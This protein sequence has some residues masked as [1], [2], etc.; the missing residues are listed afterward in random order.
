MTV[1]YLWLNAVLYALSAAW[2]SLRWAA[3]SRS[4]GYLAL[5]AGGRS[6]YLTVYGGLQLGL[7]LCFAWTALRPE[8]HRTGL[9]LALA[10]YLPIVL[11]RLSTVIGGWPVPRTTLAVAGLEL[12]LLATA[13]LL[14]LGGTREA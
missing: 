7:A 2:C 5:D 11:F 13:A 9:L 8:L 3:T 1:A 6:E 4:L 12:V 14:W 10:L